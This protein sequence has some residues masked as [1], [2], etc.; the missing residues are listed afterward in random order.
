MAEDIR[1]T[2]QPHKTSTDY[3]LELQG[4][5][6]GAIKGFDFRGR[7]RARGA[8]RPNL[9]ESYLIVA[10]EQFESNYGSLRPMQFRAQYEPEA[11]EFQALSEI[12]KLDWQLRYEFAPRVLDFRFGPN[13]FV[14]KNSWAGRNAPGKLAVIAGLTALAGCNV[15]AEFTTLAKCR[16]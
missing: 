14:S 7:L 2:L 12:R 9:S 4:R 1:L 16:I 13:A 3:L 15:L 6:S 11:V 10:L 8:L 5:F